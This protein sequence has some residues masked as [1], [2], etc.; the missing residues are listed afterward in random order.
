MKSYCSS[1][2]ECNSKCRCDKRCVNRVAQNPLAVRLQVFK[3]EK[4]SVLP[5]A[6]QDVSMLHCSSVLCSGGL[7]CIIKLGVSSIDLIVSS[8]V[9]YDFW[10]LG[11]SYFELKCN[12]KSISSLW[13]HICL[14]VLFCWFLKIYMHST[15]YLYNFL[16]WVL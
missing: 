4:R 14:W 3:T 13:N 2:Y 1:I 8:Y 15:W 9:W 16:E 7:P 11:Y 10:T 12:V 5:Q 6:W